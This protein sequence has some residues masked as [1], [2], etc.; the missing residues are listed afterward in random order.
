MLLIKCEDVFV[1]VIVFNCFKH[2]TLFFHIS[3]HTVSPAVSPLQFLLLLLLLA[4]L[5]PGVFSRPSFSTGCWS[6]GA[7]L[8]IWYIKRK[9]SAPN[10]VL[11]SGLAPA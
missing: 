10:Q 1:V 7:A 5:R 9:I 3:L 2:I 4:I 6:P 8:K 11:N